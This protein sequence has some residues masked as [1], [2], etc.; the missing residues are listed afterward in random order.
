MEY[1]QAGDVG[2]IAEKLIDN[3]H[4]HLSGM[5]MEYIFLSESPKAKGKEVWGR[6]KLITGLNAFL[7]TP[8]PESEPEP[9]F[10][11]EISKPVWDVLDANARKALVDHELSH[12][13]LDEETGTPKIITHDLEEFGGVI[14][15]WGLWRDSVEQFVEIGIAAKQLRLPGTEAAKKAAT[16]G[17]TSNSRARSSAAQAR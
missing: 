8:T 2:R 16:K 4:T 17:K 13:E 5:R 15:R 11:I 14:K 1:T 7:A 12:C 9:F 10:V 3:Y 6:A